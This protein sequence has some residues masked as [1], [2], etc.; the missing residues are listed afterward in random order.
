MNMVLRGERRLMPQQELWPIPRGE[1][2]TSGPETGVCSLAALLRFMEAVPTPLSTSRGPNA[3]R[4]VRLAA[5]AER[6]LLGVG[7]GA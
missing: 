1:H 2:P 7:S 6:T 3:G 4:Q 5:R